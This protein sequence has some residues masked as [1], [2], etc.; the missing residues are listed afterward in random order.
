[1]ARELLRQVLALGVP[2]IAAPS[3]NR[4]GR[5]SPTTAQHVREEFEG[6][7]AVLDGGACEAGI[8]SVIVDCTRGQPVLLRPGTV[9]RAT[10]EQAAGQALHERDAAAPR[11]SGTLESHYAPVAKVRL[12]AARDWPQAVHQAQATGLAGQMHAALALYSMVEPAGVAVPG[13]RWRPMPQHPREAAHELFAVLREL[14]AWLAQQGGGEI[15]VEEPPAGPQWEGVR[16]RLSR[17]A[18]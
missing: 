11:A 10:L 15:W 4:F 14:D 9:D 5:V 18:A 2:G 16:D 6:A 1:M 3:A 12:W 7:V 13:L 8:E 17:A